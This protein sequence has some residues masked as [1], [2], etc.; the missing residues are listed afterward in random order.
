MDKKNRRINLLKFIISM[1]GF[2][3]WA[4][5]GRDFRILTVSLALAAALQTYQL[6]INGVNTEISPVFNK[7]ILILGTIALMIMLGVVAYAA[8]Q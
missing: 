8:F 7:A 5:F 2:T 4:F 6:K 1:A 3:L